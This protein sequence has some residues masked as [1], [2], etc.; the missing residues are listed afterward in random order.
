MIDALLASRPTV[1]Q[2]MVLRFW[3]RLD[4][5]KAGVDGVSAWLD[6]WYAED[7]DRS[8]AWALWKREVGDQGQR[9]SDLVDRVPLGGGD[10][11]VALVK[12]RRMDEAR[13]RPARPNS[14]VPSD[15]DGPS[16]W[17]SHL[18]LACLGAAALIGIALLLMR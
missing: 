6:E 11:Y 2:R 10:T 13:S 18:L 1:R 16:V 14:D 8:E 17:R 15:T 4:L 5:L 7:P 12:S 9:T 3:N